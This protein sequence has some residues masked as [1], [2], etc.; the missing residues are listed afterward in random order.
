VAARVLVVIGA[1][2]AA[3]GLVAGHL[4]R[5]LLDGPTFATNVDDI[6]RDD[7]VAAA[8]GRSI[9]ERLVLARPDLVAIRPLVE[10]VATQAA[11]GDLLSAPTRAAAQSAHRALTES[12]ADS[13]ALRIADAGAVVSGVLGA[14]APERAPGATDVSV[15]LAHIGDQ[16]FASTMIAIARVLGVLAWLLPLL[17][18]ACFVVAV[19]LSPDRWRMAAR[20][21]RALM[22]AAGVIAVLLVIGGFLVRR[23]DDDTLGGATARA[24]WQVMIRPMWWGV[25][26]L[27]AFGLATLLACDSSAPAAIARYAGRLRGAAFGRPQSPLGVAARAIGAVIVGVAAI[28]DPIG[29]L[30]PLIVLAGIGLILYAIT[31]FARLAAPSRVAATAQPLD[32]QPPARRRWLPIGAAVLVGVLTVAGVVALA[33]PGRDVDAADTGAGSGTICNGH[34]ELCDRRFDDVAYAASHNAMSVAREP[35]WY[36]AEQID[37]I[38]VQLDQGVRAL[39]VDVWSGRPAGTVVRTAE[40]SYAEARAIAEEELGPEVVDAAL[41][42]ADSIA[43]MATGAEARFLCHGLCETGSTPFLEMLSEL[44]GWLAANPDEVVTLFIEDHVDAELIAAD[45]EAAGLL[46][47]VHE[48]A[49]G[50]PWPTL[51]EMIRSGQRLVVML[52][53]GDGGAAAPWLVNGFE[54]T[55]DTPYTFPTVESFSCE[56]NRGPAEAP[57]LLLNHWLSGFSSLVSDAQLVNATDVLLPRAQ[58]CEQERDMLPTFVAVNFVALG[59]VY[60]VVDTLNGVD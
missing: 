21:G 12:D 37:P 19:A 43:G 58:Q 32:Q 8:L 52:E 16:A 26:V 40:G 14:V 28:V 27:A 24:A 46:P 10:Q 47:Y 44:R 23:L 54:Y 41:R 59:D 20:V 4:N 31:E 9:S 38:P 45:V 48:P 3:L 15:T 53:E 13:I 25:A 51:G 30:E 34:A 36:L 22:W 42:I 60:D 57:L 50:E 1:V 55:Q 2:C 11:G 29:L 6:R 49:P 17:A 5:E 33:R 39:L 35:G 18:L 7:E 56:H